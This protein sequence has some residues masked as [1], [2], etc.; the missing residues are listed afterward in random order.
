MIDHFRST[1]DTLEG[2]ALR[3]RSYAEA[4]KGLPGYPNVRLDAK[5]AGVQVAL[6]IV[7]VELKVLEA[8]RLEALKVSDRTY[9]PS[10]RVLG[11]RADPSCDGY[12]L[13][14]D[15]GHFHAVAHIFHD[16]PQ[17]VIGCAHCVAE[18]PLPGE[19]WKDQLVL[20]AHGHPIQ[21]A[22]IP[23]GGYSGQILTAGPNGP[24]WSLPPTLGF[25]YPESPKPAS[26]KPGIPLALSGLRPTTP[27][28]LLSS[29]MHWAPED[30]PVPSEPNGDEGSAPSAKGPL[31]LDPDLRHILDLLA[32][33]VGQSEIRKLLKPVL[34]ELARYRAM[35]VLLGLEEVPPEGT[36]GEAPEPLGE[37]EL[38]NSKPAIARRSEPASEID[39]RE[40]PATAVPDDYPAGKCDC[41]RARYMGRFGPQCP[42]CDGEGV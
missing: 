5:A 26:D 32:G 22:A 39:Q 27:A 6:D 30:P 18:L 24:Q 11:Y 1:R 31:T 35:F 13:A 10:R 21:L 3:L 29:M 14:L 37:P 42:A 12:E 36:K 41:G 2:L 16:K 38:S 19:A 25:S 8:Q 33:Y 40:S 9:F 4:V 20:D 7:D 15:C 23:S 17:H 34:V 28:A